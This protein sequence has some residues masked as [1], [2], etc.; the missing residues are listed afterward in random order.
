[1]QTQVKTWGNSQGIRIPREILQN[2]GIV[3][4]E[5]LDITVANG[6]ITLTKTFR[7]KTL[8]ER[9][10]EFGGKLNLDGEYDWGDPVGREVWE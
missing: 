7:H 6:V 5:M 9:A 1:M 10:A 4:N 8:E 2:A 3:L